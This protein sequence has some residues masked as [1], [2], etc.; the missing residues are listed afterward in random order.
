MTLDL[1]TMRGALEH[2][3]DRLRAAIESVNHTG[4]L[5]EET[6]DLAIGSDDHIAD[7]ATETFMRE[8]DEGLEE[9]AE[10]LLDEVEA[11]LRRI[12]EDTYGTCEVCGR[13]IS[14]ARLEAV[15]WARL[16]IDDKRAQE[17]RR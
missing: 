3:R 5:E 8:L 4:S 13:P 12:D 6:G 15:P 11:A 7:S 1:G 17:G 14:E 16:C 10:H 9:N 2:E